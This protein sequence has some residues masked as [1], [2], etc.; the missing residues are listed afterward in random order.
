MSNEQGHGLSMQELLPSANGVPHLTNMVSNG[1]DYSMDM[2]PRKR[3]ESKLRFYLENL[4][5][6]HG[7]RVG[8][9]AIKKKVNYILCIVGDNLSKWRGQQIDKG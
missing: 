6:F 9:N 5:I 8:R 2:R 4:K 3:I 1:K 7:S